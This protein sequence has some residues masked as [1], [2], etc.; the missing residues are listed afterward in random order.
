MQGLFDNKKVND[1]RK[2]HNV[3]LSYE[4]TGSITAQ[5][6]LIQ[7]NVLLYRLN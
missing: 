2:K 4:S 1:L 7:K 3:G 5:F 6:F